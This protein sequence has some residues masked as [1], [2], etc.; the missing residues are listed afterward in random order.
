MIS[1]LQLKLQRNADYSMIQKDQEKHKLVHLHFLQKKI[2]S[3]QTVKSDEHENIKTEKPNYK[4]T[5]NFRVTKAKL[6]KSIKPKKHRKLQNSFDYLVFFAAPAY[7][8]LHFPSRRK[9]R[10]FFLHITDSQLLRRHR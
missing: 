6:L 5:T 10:T 9:P 3:N 7:S 8:G 4:R 1:A 2:Q